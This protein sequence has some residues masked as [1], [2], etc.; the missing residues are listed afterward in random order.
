MTLASGM[1]KG[2]SSRKKEQDA[3]NDPCPA[4]IP[5]LPE[6]STGDRDEDG[7]Q[8]KDLDSLTVGKYLK[9]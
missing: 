2:P 8:S 7:D 6:L 9:P 5:Q 1:V 4:L 3:G